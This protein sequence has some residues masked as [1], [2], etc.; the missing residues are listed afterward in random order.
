MEDSIKHAPF[1]AGVRADV[2]EYI[3][4]NGEVIVYERFEAAL[5]VGEFDQDPKYKQHC[6]TCPRFGR[7]L[8]CPPFSPAFA[9]YVGEVRTATVICL[10]IP[11]EYFD[12]PDPDKRYRA[13]HRMAQELLTQELMRYRQEGY[14]VLGS[15][16]CRACK[17]CTVEKGSRE[18]LQPDKRIYSLESLGV[19]VVALVKSAMG[20]DL[21]WSGSEDASGYVS[22]VGAVFQT[23]Q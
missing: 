3:D 5:A 20:F 1:R 8:A 7:N 2:L 15:G 17:E 4:K 13:G 14:L 23:E 10:R 6:E 21:D 12:E 18:C 11:L 9:G 22:A 19:N 16:T